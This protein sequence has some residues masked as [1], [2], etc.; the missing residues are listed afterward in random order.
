[1]S[2][3]VKLSA[4]IQFRFLN[5]KLGGEGE[6][7]VTSPHLAPDPKNN[8]HPVSGSCGLGDFQVWVAITQ[9]QVVHT[10]SEVQE[11]WASTLIPEQNLVGTGLDLGLH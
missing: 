5:T 2:Y 10:R 1:M 3:A 11:P 4:F 8:E 7:S 9:I 6:A